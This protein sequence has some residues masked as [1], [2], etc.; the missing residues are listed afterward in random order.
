[1]KLG[2]YYYF[3]FKLWDLDW[4]KSNGLP[5]GYRIS[6]LGGRSWS[7]QLV[8]QRKGESEVVLEWARPGVN[9][10]P[11]TIPLHPDGLQETDV[12]WWVPGLTLF[13][14]QWL[15]RFPSPWRHLPCPT[16]YVM[17]FLWPHPKGQAVLRGFVQKSEK[18][19]R[20]VP[21]AWWRWVGKS[22]QEWGL[23]RCLRVTR[24]VLRRPISE[25]Q[26]LK[27]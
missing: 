16:P 1:M 26:T 17:L 8:L 6:Q 2:K 15:I 11:A 5:Q 10:G 14:P 23:G 18:M 12:L 19:L 22:Y 20:M 21:G 25:S 9:A 7:S 3:F 4:E 13:L 24:F 27:D